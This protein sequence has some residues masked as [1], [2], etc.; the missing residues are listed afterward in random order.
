MKLNDEYNAHAQP[1]SKVFAGGVF[2]I[3]NYDL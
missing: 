3:M 1:Q 2:G